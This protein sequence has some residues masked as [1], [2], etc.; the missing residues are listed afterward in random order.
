MAAQSHFQT[1]TQGGLRTITLQFE[2]KKVTWGLVKL[3]IP[4]QL[5]VLIKQV[6]GKEVLGDSGTAGLNLSRR[7][8]R[9]RPAGCRPGSV[10]CPTRVQGAGRAT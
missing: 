10:L 4:E 9:K 6:Y 1:K 2:W 3:S 7:N 8:S 5:Q